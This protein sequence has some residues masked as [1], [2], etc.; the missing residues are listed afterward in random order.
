MKKIILALVLSGTFNLVNAQTEKG[1]CLVGGRVDINAADQNTHIGFSPNAG[2]FVAHNFAVGANLLLDYSKSGGT[3]TTNFGIGPFA[4]Y[5][6]TNAM[7]KPLVQVAVNYVSSKFSTGG[8]SATNDAASFFL[9]GG[10]AVFINEN[11]SL[12]PIMGYSNT[13]GTSGF[14]FGLGF[15]VYLSK[16]QV[17]KVRGK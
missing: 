9:G 14:S 7:V 1:D 3:K 8:F 12:E 16:R 17:D 11:V 2:I 13:D 4:R 5:Y 15:Q 6:F 10:V